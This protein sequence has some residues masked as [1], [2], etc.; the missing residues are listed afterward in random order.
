MTRHTFRRL[1]PVAAFA[2]FSL[3]ARASASPAEPGWR[4]ERGPDGTALAC[5][6]NFPLQEVGS[7][8]ASTDC[9][10][11]YIA[12]GRNSYAVA[13]ST[14]TVRPPGS[15][16]AMNYRLGDLPLG[17]PVLLLHGTRQPTRVIAR[18]RGDRVDFV[19]GQTAF[20]APPPHSLLPRAVSASRNDATPT[21]THAVAARRASGGELT[22]T[23]RAQGVLLTLRADGSF[24]RVSHSSYG[25]FGAG[26]MDDHGSYELHGNEVVLSGMRKRTCVY[27]G[28]NAALVCSGVSYRME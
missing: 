17:E 20:K 10:G 22:G 1:V 11:H 23:W 19:V 15:F 7:G 3:P 27:D 5:N 9:D 28:R 12:L 25:V 13:N 18:R 8:D 26:V 16:H 4:Q 24:S 6:F 2:L 14:I 21:P